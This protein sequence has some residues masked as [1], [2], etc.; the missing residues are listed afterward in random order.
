MEQWEYSRITTS[1]DDIVDALNRAGGDGWELVHVHVDQP[2]QN[3]IF[4]H[5]R[6]GTPPPP[7]MCIAFLKRPKSAQN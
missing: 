1:L 7:A 4:F 5:Q 3:Q 6:A 2:D